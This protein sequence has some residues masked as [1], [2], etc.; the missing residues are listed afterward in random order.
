MGRLG[1]GSFDRFGS[2]DLD[3]D[4]ITILEIF[5][6]NLI[7]FFSTFSDKLLISAAEKIL[8][9]ALFGDLN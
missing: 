5:I 7:C 9:F 8:S 3:R 4:E 6:R 1:K 2:S